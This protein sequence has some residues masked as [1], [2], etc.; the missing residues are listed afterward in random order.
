MKNQT[1]DAPIRDSFFDFL[2]KGETCSL[3]VENYTPFFYVKVS[4]KWNDQIKR[5]FLSYII[6][7]IVYP[8]AIFAANWLPA[9]AFFITTRCCDCGC[10]YVATDAS[11]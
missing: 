5:K 8:P 2:E 9:A 4:D 10:Y 3:M 6:G 11:F 1:L 7:R